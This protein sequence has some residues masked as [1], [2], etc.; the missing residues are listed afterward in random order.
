MAGTPNARQSARRDNRRAFTLV[1]MLVVIAIIGIL[2][3]LLLPAV[4]AAREAARRTQCQNNLKQI[5]I[6]LHTYRNNWECF[7]PAYISVAVDEP[8]WGWGVFLLDY[9]ERQPLVHELQPSERRL[10]DVL[11][12]NRLRIW[13]KSPLPEFRCPSDR[14]PKMLPHTL[15]PFYPPSTGDRFEPSKS[16]YVAVCGLY[17]RADGMENN[18]VMYGNSEVDIREIPDGTSYTFVIGERHRRCGAA[19]WIG[20]RNPYGLSDLGAYF[21][22]G[23]V[24]IKLNEP[25][26]QGPDT[27]REGFSSAH[28]GGGH[29]LFCDGAVRFMADNLSFSNGTVDVYA[30]TGTFDRNQGYDLGIYQ[31]LGIRNDDIPFRE[32]WE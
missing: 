19:T 32:E 20:N 22:Q 3:A 29:F 30:Q 4:Q 23:R 31:L 7:P 26:D 2:V 24:S 15:R 27:C 16:N 11:A 17:D 10:K 25:L 18:G 13:L 14:T 8:D 9:M 5:G 28:S 21:V 6:A 1:E 12:D